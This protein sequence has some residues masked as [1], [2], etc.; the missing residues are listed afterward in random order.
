M[1]RF[2]AEYYR[3]FYLDPETSVATQAEVDLRAAAIY[4]TARSFDIP[5]RKVIDVGGGIGLFGSSFKRLDRAIHYT[6]LEPSGDALRIAKEARGAD[7]D[8]ALC[9]S[10]SSFEGDGK[11]YDVVLCAGVVQ[12]LDEGE[13][14]DL[15]DKLG[16]MTRYLL[17]FETF[18]EEDLRKRRIDKRSDDGHARAASFYVN[19]LKRRGLVHLGASL[20]F[21]EERIP[22]V[23]WE[24]DR[25]RP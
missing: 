14:E 11:G 2:D 1:S 7:I 15:F 16:E 5:V 13:V 25:G 12:Y 23:P 20:F 18:T 3:R 21:R 10:A 17:F 24:L 6:L 4:Y 22:V 9:E 19:A 8:L